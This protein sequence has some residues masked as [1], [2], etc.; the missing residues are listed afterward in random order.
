MYFATLD[1]LISSPSFNSS[2]WMR[3]APQSGF[4][5]AR[6]RISART[7]PATVGRPVRRRLFQ[8]QNSRKPCRC[9]AM[10]VS[11]LTMMIAA[12]HSVHARDSQVQKNR[13]TGVSRTR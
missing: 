12:R 4:A 7:S 1:W 13:S 2:P 11:G 10:T 6:V 9:H 5:A 3:G 8:R